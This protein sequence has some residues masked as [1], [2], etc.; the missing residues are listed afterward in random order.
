MMRRLALAS[1]LLALVAVL[2]WRATTTS[3]A[4]GIVNLLKNP[5][6]EDNYDA[7]GVYRELRTAEGWTPWWVEREGDEGYILRRPECKPSDHYLFAHRVKSGEYAQQC[8]TFFGTHEMGVYQ[9]VAVQPGQVLLFSV[10]AQVWSTSTSN[11][12]FSELPGN[13]RVSVGIDPTGGMD[14]QSPVIHWSDEIEAYDRWHFQFVQEVA[15]NSVVTVYTRSRAQFAVKHNDVYWDEAGLVDANLALSLQ[16]TP[17]PTATPK[18]TPTLGPD[19]IL[20]APPVTDTLRLIAARFS[21]DFA[22][23]ARSNRVPANVAVRPGLPVV[24]PG[25]SQRHVT[26]GTYAVQTGETLESIAARFQYRTVELSLINRRFGPGLTWPGET[27]IV[28]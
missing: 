27:L 6:F 1:L 11:P 4:Q 23:V 16:L 25:G 2:T 9:R 10:W 18:P 7:H 24:V 3:A 28:P 17:I 5:S 26:R 15:Q 13:V 12:T 8:F 21:V 20:Y 19:S 14:P 22:T